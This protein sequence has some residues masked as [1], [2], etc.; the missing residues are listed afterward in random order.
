MKANV[1]NHFALED[2]KNS[3][4]ALLKKVFR[5]E[6]ISVLYVKPEECEV[7]STMEKLRSVSEKAVLAELNRL[8]DVLELGKPADITKQASRY[9]NLQSSLKNTHHNFCVKVKREHFGE[10]QTLVYVFHV[11]NTSLKILFEKYGRVD[12]SSSLFNSISVLLIR[13]ADL[14][15][16]HTARHTRDAVV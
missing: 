13:Y 11:E 2:A 1:E 16:E 12:S 7:H 3:L 10:I 9:P 15:V 4:K 14:I 6:Q 8:S 5:I